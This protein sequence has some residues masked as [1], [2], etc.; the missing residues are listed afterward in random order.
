MKT[1]NRRNWI[2]STALWTTGLAVAPSAVSFGNHPARSTWVGS[3][4]KDINWNPAVS[5]TPL[6]AKLNANENPYGPSDSAKQ[7]LMDAIQ[8]G[9]RY[10]HQQAAELRTKLAMMEGVDKA[11]I[12]LAPGST[13]ILEK[14]AIAQFIDG[15]NVVSG[16]PAYM[17]LIN[18]AMAFKA[19]W[20][21]VPLT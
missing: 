15:G 13:D 8:V 1:I 3:R 10:G 12:M 16:D 7:A 11:S 6:L 9:N 19:D 4:F 17:S 20:N 5:N 21:K 2:R 18:T 14:V